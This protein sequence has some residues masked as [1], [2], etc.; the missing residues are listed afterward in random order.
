M[1]LIEMK[2]VSV[3]ITCNDGRELSA[4]GR[5]FDVAGH[6]FVAHRSISWPNRAWSVTCAETGLSLTSDHDTQREAIE[7]SY[8]V[9][10]RMDNHGGPGSF[11]SQ[12]RMHKEI[13]A[14][15]VAA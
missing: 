8:R 13:A 1:G 10:T 12:M 11:D 2:N 6:R 5:A 14:R 15:G 9:V 3:K 4:S 7:A